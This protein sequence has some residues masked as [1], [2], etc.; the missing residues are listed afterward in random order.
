MKIPKIEY[1]VYSKTNENKLE[2]LNL[3]ICDHSKISLYIPIKITENIDKLNISSGYYNDI[4]YTSTSDSGTDIS[5]KNRKQEF[6]YGN[7]T[8]CQEDC[9]F[10]DYDYIKQRAKCSC[11]VKESSSSSYNNMKI[12]KLK[13]FK[14]FIDLNNIANVKILSCFE[15][16]LIINS[17]IKNI[18][19]YTL[20]IIIFFHIGIIIIFYISQIDKIKQR[21]IEI[22]LELSSIQ[23]IKNKKSKENK[24]NKKIIQ[25][26]E[27]IN[28]DKS[29]KYI[30][31]I[32]KKAR[33]RKR[34][35]RKEKKIPNKYI[36]NYSET[37]KQTINKININTNIFFNINMNNND[38]NNNKIKQLN[39]INSKSI[40]K[41]N[42]EKVKIMKYKEDEIND[43][44]FELALL[45]DKRSFLQYYY[46]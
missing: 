43:L 38:I 25:E 40:I 33:G 4:C 42:K 18:G 3:S 1:D 11:K 22:R 10:S 32:I 12:D 34:K 37:K 8:V 5:L 46:Y 36:N 27:K 14:N 21:I 24:V 16:L 44:S 45:Y 15:K 41:I 20:I 23:L 17:L 35:K 9:D 13:I 39:S 6:I 29:N 2:K 28:G 7:K 19:N 26:I 31:P 30:S